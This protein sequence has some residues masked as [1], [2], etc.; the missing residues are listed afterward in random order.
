MHLALG[1]CCLVVYMLLIVR[2][3]KH[4]HSL[5]SCQ[6]DGEYLRQQLD[7]DKRRHS[8]LI[9]PFVG[10]FSQA[11]PTV[12]QVMKDM[13]ELMGYEVQFKL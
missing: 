7:C 1:R 12:Y 3:W 10:V 5:H 13:L 11:R 8:T 9:A 2:C 6:Q 4:S